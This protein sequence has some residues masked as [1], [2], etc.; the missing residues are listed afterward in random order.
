MRESLCLQ[1]TLTQRL[2]LWTI[3]AVVERNGRKGTDKSADA[4]S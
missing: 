4:E 2:D 1:D 3:A